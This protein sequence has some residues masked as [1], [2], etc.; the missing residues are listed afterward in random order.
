MLSFAAT[1]GWWVMPAGAQG[2]ANR[3]AGRADWPLHNLDLRNSRY[4]PLNEITVSNASKLTVKQYVS[5]VATNT[6]LTLAV[7]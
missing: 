2:G 3:Q 1:A 5:V 4:S 7:P 6:I